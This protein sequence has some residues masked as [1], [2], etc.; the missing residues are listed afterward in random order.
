MPRVTL[1]DFSVYS[2][3]KTPY[4]MLNK[5]GNWWSGWYY[6]PRGIVAVYREGG[7]TRLSLSDGC[8]V[9]HRSWARY[10]GDRT[11]SRLAREFI[12]DLIDRPSNP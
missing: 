9:C 8:R 6:H 1:E 11:I 12:R 3:G 10:W 4:L 5:H 7:Y 2:S